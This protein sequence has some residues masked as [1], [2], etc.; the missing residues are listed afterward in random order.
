MDTYIVLDIET[1]GIS[2][3]FEEITEIGAARVSDGKVI[4][5]FS[6]L[7]NPGKCIPG[8]IVVL[9]GIT[10]KM[11]ANAPAISLVMPRFIEFCG[12]LPI[13]GHNVAFDY[14]FLKTAAKRCGLS[15]E[16]SGLDTMVLTRVFL[17]RQRSYSLSNLI[18]AMGIQRENAHRGLDDA[19]ATSELYEILR[20][21]YKKPLN[22]KYF[23]PKPII[24]R[25]KK[26]SPMTEKQ[27][28]FLNSLI[29][30]HNVAID[31]VVDD[32]SKSEASKKIDQ[33]LHTYGRQLN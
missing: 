5:T 23:E 11:V 2:P 33:I 10:D 13:L 22:T 18:L 20:R 24:Y 32:L 14:S 19:L 6:E 26:Q 4:E 15:F 9:T 7:V 30:K 25:P 3:Q 8:N 29:R 31:Y 1:T 12:D 28:K 21:R 16:K 27:K 17:E